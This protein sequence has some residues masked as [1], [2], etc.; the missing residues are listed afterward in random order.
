MLSSYPASYP[1]ILDIATSLSLNKLFDRQEG[2]DMTTTMDTSEN[3]D[4][5]TC[6]QCGQPLIHVVT[7]WICPTH[8]Q[9]PEPKQFTP[10]R[11]FLSYGHDASRSQGG[12]V[13]ELAR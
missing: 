9:V 1:A 12:V 5:R 6:P 3:N 7:F 13:D 2:R 8:G 11:I 10:L 4:G